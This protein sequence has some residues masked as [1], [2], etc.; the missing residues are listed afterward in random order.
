MNYVRLPVGKDTGA[1]HGFSVFGL[2]L[3]F[4][5]CN[6]VNFIKKRLDSMVKICI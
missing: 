6:F 3:L 4:S 2:I 1:A 5:I